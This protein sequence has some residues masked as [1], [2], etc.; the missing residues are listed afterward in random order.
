M[1]LAKDKPVDSK[2]KVMS[3]TA[4]FFCDP[5]ASPPDLGNRG[6]YKGQLAKK[7]SPCQLVCSIKHTD[8]IPEQKEKKS[9]DINF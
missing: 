6:E 3:S 9:I 5:Q 8:N 7:Q 4:K 1:A 2:D